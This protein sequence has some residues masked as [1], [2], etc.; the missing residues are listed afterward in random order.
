MA[1]TLSGDEVRAFYDRFG[2]RQ[3][4]QAF[5][6]DP[7][8]DELIGH[9]AFEGAAAV[10]EFGC[11]TG[12]F[13]ERL[14]AQ[15]LPDCC[16]YK[17]VDI[18]STM[19]TLARRRLEPWRDRVQLCLTSGSVALKQAGV[20]YDRFVAT[21]VLDLLGD[22]DIR[23]LLAEAHRILD[24]DG[25]LCLVSLTKGA[26]AATVPVSALWTA[27]NALRP[28]ALGGCRPI[29]MR[30]YVTAP[31]WRIRHR[32]V[33]VAYGIS[34]EVLVAAPGQDRHEEARQP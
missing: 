4:R 11:G 33:C 8:L 26:T 27:I 31:D 19:V 18:S 6:E 23:R 24:Q 30:R 32:K 16:S 7:A 12:R 13:A 3:D 29:E 34:S 15:H 10:C 17:G 21:Y 2:A 20:T 5:Y 22:D 9:A 28:A 25:L 14:L 1:R